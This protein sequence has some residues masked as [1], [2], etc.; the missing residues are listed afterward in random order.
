MNNGLL[1]LG[2]LLVA[3]LAALFAVPNFVDWNSYRG[4]FEEEASKVLG[5][6]VR[7]GG[8]VNLKLLPVPYVRFEKL[9]IA[10]VT[11][12]TGEPFVRAD[13]FTMW[14][15]VAALLRGVLEASQVEL[16]KPVLSLSVDDNGVGNWAKLDLKSGDLPFVPRDVALRSVRITDGAISLYNAAAV[17]VAAVDG[18][19]GVFS[20]DGIRGP[21][22]YSGLATWG[23]TDHDIKFA[24]DVPTSEGV[25]TLKLAARADRSPNTF[26]LDGRLNGIGEKTSFKGQWSGKMQVPGSPSVEP[27]GKAP[28]LINVRSDVTADAQGAKLENLMLTLDNAAEPQT[29]SGKAVASWSSAPRLDVS[30]NS[31]WLD[32]DWLAGAGKDSAGF[33]K[34]KQLVLG[35][36]QS[37]AGDSTASAKINLEQVKIGG[38]NSG[39]LS[40]DAERQGNVTHLKTFKVSLPGGSRLDLAGDVK[41]KAGKLSFAGNGF[42]GGSSFGRLKAWTEKSG[43]PI[44]INAE[45]PY[46]AAGKL[47]I[48]DA[49]FLLTEAS[50]DISGRPLAGELKI[51]HGERE[52]TEL[53]LQAAELDTREVFPKITEALRA[54]FR[55]AL[56][57]AQRDE[58][59]D[60]QQD[61]PGDVRLRVIAGR[62][63]DGDDTYRDVDVSLAT[64]G[65]KLSLPVAKITS[66]S[67]LEIGLEGRVDMREGGPIGQLAYD[68]VGPSADAIQDLARKAG[69]AEMI[70]G[71]RLKGLTGGKLA[72]L[73][74]LGMRAPKSADIT[75]DGLL[76]ASKIDGKAEFDEGIREWRTR[77]SRL[78]ATLEA[79]SL[80]DMLA[81]LGREGQAKPAP[82]SQP[83]V[84]SL[85]STGTLSSGS[86]SQIEL[87]G[88]DLKTRFRGTA[89]WTDKLDLALN[90]AVDVKALHADDVLALAGISLPGA[91]NGIGMQ[92][93]LDVQRENGAWSIA[94]Q[95][96][97]LGSS[98][99]SGRLTAAE[100]AK[101]MRI[102]GSIVA[103]RVSVPGLFAT[104]ADASPQ[105]AP[106][107]TST[108]KTNGTPDT[109]VPVQ[110]AVW[111]EGLFNFS[112]LEN[113][114][115]NVQ[116]AFKS[117]Q[118]N[119]GFA[120]GEGSMT[121]DLA[122]GRM[123]IRDLKA[124][125]AGGQ[126]AGV[127]RLEKVSNGV[128]LTTDLKLEGAKLAAINAGG[129]GAGTFD[130][131]AEARAQSPAGLV[132]VM[133]GSGTAKFAGAEIAGP[134]ASTVADVVDDVLAG[135]VQNDAQAIGN[136]LVAAVGSSR[137]ALGDRSLPISLTDG[138][139]KIADINV[140]DADGTVEG[141]ATADLSSLAMS[142]S[143]QVTS[144]LRPLL[145]VAQPGPTRAQPAPKGPLP[146]VVVLYG[147]DLG[148]LSAVAV[149]ADVGNLQRELV[150]RQMERNV[151][152]L[153][154]A[155]RA[156]DERS[157][158][159]RE[160]ER[161]RNAAADRA[162]AQQKAQ[163]QQLPPVIPESAGTATGGQSSNP[164]SPDD[165]FGSAP[166]AGASAQPPA[167]QGGQPTTAVPPADGAVTGAQGAA[168]QPVVIDPATGLPVPKPTPAVKPYAARSPSKPVK[169]RTSSDEVI[170]SLG[171]F[172]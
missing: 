126:L 120:T 90:G 55:K 52:R 46:S 60:P 38:E 73:I 138:T 7:V 159:D 84:A 132:A 167:Q 8:N 135:K 87:S 98:L 106:A 130:L 163:Q 11:G 4:V 117:L 125:A 6:D 34:L 129:N 13:S 100:D 145:P 94:S 70:G 162:A 103:E 36:M 61:L 136:A 25:V 51:T 59:R 41:N 3:I 16:E 152:E 139:L 53:V 76:N 74:R 169:S 96:V 168:A 23:G 79:T 105:A 58:D 128:A 57:I 146:P 97:A 116:L 147:G 148:Q 83:A 18:I 12:Q 154:Q 19:D 165:F 156:D 77:P 17:K 48:D 133:T 166:P 62:L 27:A 102:G 160:M 71:D 75:F 113:T 119:G 104:V 66:Q 26:V 21:F 67:G 37:V 1:F 89:R 14:L 56:G 114:T 86:L 9:R 44:D 93:T 40:I 110:P 164:A 143:F 24:T 54:E 85:I 99:V 161:K 2:A 28:P 47:E 155:R 64:E 91:V 5:R 131:H 92:G 35:L 10:S 122:P 49:R 158:I 31:K 50:G 144:T 140:K 82:S 78:Q 153:E 68:A 157:R 33:S 142:A 32:V 101:S 109:T 127:A 118:V 141:T 15:S 107:T 43:F 69:L 22:R 72:G 63:T 108:G 30:L 121:V 20:A 29:V 65:Q 95:N 172:P 124:N 149:T 134:A 137:I 123:T 112:A 150:V 115:G 88:Q 171:G 45:G 111:P 81:L 170:R 42:I 80:P 151:E 39:G